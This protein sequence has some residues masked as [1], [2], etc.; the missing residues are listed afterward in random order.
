MTSTFPPDDELSFL[1]DE[2]ILDLEAQDENLEDEDDDEDG[3]GGS[4]K[5]SGDGKKPYKVDPK[6]LRKL[7]EEQ[8]FEA[9]EAWQEKMRLL[10]LGPF[11]SIIPGASAFDAESDL[12]KKILIGEIGI[13]THQ[14]QPSDVADPNLIENLQARLNLRQDEMR[15]I[16]S[17]MIQQAGLVT[18][19]TNAALSIST[20]LRQPDIKTPPLK[21]KDITAIDD[22]LNERS[23]SAKREQVVRVEEEEPKEKKTQFDN[24]LDSLIKRDKSVF[25][26]DIFDYIDNKPDDKSSFASQIDYKE[27]SLP[28]G[29]RPAQQE[30]SGLQDQF[31]KAVTQTSQPAQA[32]P[33]KQDINFAINDPSSVLKPKMDQ[34]KF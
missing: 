18:G 12:K 9:D 34:F 11:S 22:E 28:Q 5:K 2:E 30:T 21:E 33:L 20:E 4:G 17:T 32:M 27:K 24:N 14:I 3:E 23:L 19:I 7:L 15:N 25:D 29:Q 31:N 6:E 26:S 16:A 1:M 10:A 13:L 8:E